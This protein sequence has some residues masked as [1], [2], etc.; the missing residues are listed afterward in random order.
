MRRHIEH[1]VNLSANIECKPYSNRL[2][3][4]VDM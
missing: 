3:K 2:C 4:L 1:E